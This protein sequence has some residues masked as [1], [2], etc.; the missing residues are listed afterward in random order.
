MQLTFI[1]SARRAFFFSSSALVMGASG[2]VPNLQCTGGLAPVADGFSKVFVTEPVGDTMMVSFVI[3]TSHLTV[4]NYIYIY[5][6]THINT[7]NG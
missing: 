4:V 7:H 3:K 1:S 5:I 6:Y 2:F